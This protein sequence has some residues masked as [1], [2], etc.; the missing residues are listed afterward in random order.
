[1]TE[2][3]Q[4]RNMQEKKEFYSPSTGIFF[5]IRDLLYEENSS[6]QKIEVF[7]NDYFGKILVLDG[8]IQT[9]EKDE[10][11]YHEMLVHP[12]LVT[13]SDPQNILVIGG[14]DGGVLKEILRYPVKKV[15]LVEIDGQVIDVAKKYFPWLSPALKDE[16]VELVISDGSE[17]IQKSRKKFDVVIVDS[18]EPV[19]PSLTL[20][21]K[22]FYEG[23][24]SR[25]TKG[26]IVL[27]QVGS[28]FYHFKAFHEK[29]SFLKNIF[30]V[31]SF[32]TS[33]VPTYPGGSWGYVFLSEGTQ[34]TNIKRNPP[35][36]LKYYNLDV[37]RA[38][39]MLPNFLKKYV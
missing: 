10:F 38:A 15:C 28:P 9:T 2:K 12:S 39:F 5:K 19:G 3:N 18:S 24:K 33:P 30:Q 26:G 17:F 22:D 32:Y 6:F 29:A 20:H 23:L 7:Q 8:L 27:A 34:P 37:H 25:L 16:R 35:P 36:G 13:H 21:A 11:F 4:K 1:M 31:V 14:G